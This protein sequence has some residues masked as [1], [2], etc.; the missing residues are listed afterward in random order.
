MKQKSQKQAVLQLFLNGQT[1]NWL[2]AFKQ[3]GC[4]SVGRR[5]P[6]F[7]KQGLVFKREK[8]NFKTRFGTAG[9]YMNYTLDLKKTPKKV[10]KEVS[11]A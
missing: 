8:V 3:T 6:E 7:E 1:L 9:S 2:S 5:V 10:L 4:S 11:K